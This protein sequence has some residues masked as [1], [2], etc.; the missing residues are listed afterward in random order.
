MSR[1]P[2][3]RS[4]AA[5]LRALTPHAGPFRLLSARSRDWASALFVGARHRLVLA[6]EGDD[7]PARAERLGRTLAEL[8]LAMR[9]GFVADIQAVVQMD[10]ATP[11][12]AIEALTIE[13]AEPDAAG[14]ISAGA[15]RRAG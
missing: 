11:V 10:S 4:R 2:A 15:R 8:D 7:G 13:E 6:M 1:F 5:L 12:L 14:A 3:D 9:D